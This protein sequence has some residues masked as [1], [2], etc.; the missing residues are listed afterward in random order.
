VDELRTK[1]EN[2]IK[3]LAYGRAAGGRYKEIVK[4]GLSEYFL[5]TIEGRE[6]I[7]SGEAKRLPSFEQDGVPAENLYKYEKDRYGDAPV[8]FLSFKNDE[9]HKLGKEPLPNGMVKVFRSLDDEG[10]LEYVGWKEVQYIPLGEDVELQLGPSRDVQVKPVL[11][12]YKQ[13]HFEFDR[14]GNISGWDDEKWME[15]T[16]SNHRPIAIR[17]EC[18][19]NIGHVNWELDK[20]G[21]FGEYEKIDMDTVQFTLEL[22]PREEKVFTYHLT[23]H[24]GSR[25]D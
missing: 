12:D 4:E 3:E 25:A 16:V 2:E 24:R 1:A 23:E 14:R 7:P 8:R 21:A 22:A 15:V 19:F 18:R 10:H 11:M 9:E 13:T 17:V 20:K 5:Y 6:A